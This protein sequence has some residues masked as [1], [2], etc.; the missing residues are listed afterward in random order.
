MQIYT[1][2]NQDEKPTPEEYEAEGIETVPADD[3][4]RIMRVVRQ[5]TIKSNNIKGGSL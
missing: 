2:R 5:R 3:L 4:K 1:N